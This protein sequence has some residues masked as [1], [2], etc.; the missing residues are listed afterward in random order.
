MV[1]SQHRYN[2]RPLPSR[3]L[4]TD[5]STLHLSSLSSNSALR[6][7]RQPAQPFSTESLTTHLSD[8]VPQPFTSGVDTATLLSSDVQTAYFSGNLF[9]EVLIPTP[10]A[11]HVQI[12]E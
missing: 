7:V 3:R 8:F 9:S 4:S 12:L 2:I 10:L 6:L 1:T 11:P 5:N